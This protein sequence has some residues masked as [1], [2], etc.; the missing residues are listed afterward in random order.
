MGTAGPNIVF[1]YNI[2]RTWGF[3]MR[4][5]FMFPV[6]GRQNLADG[7][8]DGQAIASMYDAQRI[9]FDVSFMVSR[10]L[11]LNADLDLVVAAGIHVQTL[12]LVSTVY[13]PI[14]LITG[15]FGGVARIERKIDERFFYGGEL[16][17]AFDPLDFI[18]HD[19]RAV[20][21]APVSLSVLIG[22]RR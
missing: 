7:N 4:G 9:A 2:G 14:E 6:T 15:G 12:R 20:Y 16:S 3:A 17:F 18:Q 8:G 5:A 19:N 22:V 1:D 10:R 11:H 13:N 21:V